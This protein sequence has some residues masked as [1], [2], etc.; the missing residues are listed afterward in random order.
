MVE[1][2]RRWSKMVENG[3]LEIQLPSTAFDRLR[4]P[5]TIFDRATAPLYRS[6]ARNGRIIARFPLPPDQAS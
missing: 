5:S 2:G 4:P 6:E 3:V 1:D